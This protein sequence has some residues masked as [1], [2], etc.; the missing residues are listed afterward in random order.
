MSADQKEASDGIKS[1]YERTMESAKGIESGSALSI[2]AGE[3]NLRTPPKLPLHEKIPFLTPP[4]EKMQ[5]RTLTDYH[6]NI[7]ILLNGTPTDIANLVK[8]INAIPALDP[9]QGLD[10]ELQERLKKEFN[11]IRFYADPANF[12]RLER[13]RME[14]KK[15]HLI[16]NPMVLPRSPLRHLTAVSAENRANPQAALFRTPTKFPAQ[17]TLM[18]T[19][20]RP[21][22]RT[23]SIEIASSFRLS[24]SWA[25]IPKKPIHPPIPRETSVS[26][27]KNGS[28]PTH[29][30]N[31]M[32]QFS[33]TKQRANIAH[34]DFAPMYHSAATVATVAFTQPP[35]KSPQRAV[36]IFERSS[37][38]T[39]IDTRIDTKIRDEYEK[40][41]FD[42]K[43]MTELSIPPSPITIKYKS[44]NGQQNPEG[45]ASPKTLE[46]LKL[47]MAKKDQAYRKHL[48]KEIN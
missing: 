7:N 36:S 29:V 16:H 48:H 23:S 43:T 21:I 44:G 24:P 13:F 32:L 30:P 15:R 46:A 34:T 38:H 9:F 26:E 27:R 40:E 45:F 11:F 25:L 33:P 39:A 3:L 2:P 17:S 20:V 35:T 12:R 5:P 22:S 10:P 41:T 1:F 4:R 28:N 42:R 37:A 6:K 18:G 14:F 31:G 8:E 47:K 19:P